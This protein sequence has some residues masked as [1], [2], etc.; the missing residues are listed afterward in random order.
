[1]QPLRNVRTYLADFVESGRDLSEFRLFH[2]LDGE[3]T[4]LDGLA[5]LHRPETRVRLKTSHGR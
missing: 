2:E 4:V 5:L 1:M 3:R